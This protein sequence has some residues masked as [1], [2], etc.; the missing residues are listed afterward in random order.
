VPE[1]PSTAENISA[2]TVRPSR[3]R[4]VL[5]SA[6]PSDRSIENSRQLQIDL[7]AAI[8]EFD[9]RVFPDESDVF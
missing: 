9:L 7:L 6:V 3:L 2:A 8:V 4:S 1:T 5:R